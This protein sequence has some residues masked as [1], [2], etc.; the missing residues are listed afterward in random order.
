MIL[1]NLF[2]FL[3]LTLAISFTTTQI[4]HK[5]NK[6]PKVLAKLIGTENCHIHFIIDNEDYHYIS[7]IKEKLNIQVTISFINDSFKDAFITLLQ[8]DLVRNKLNN[9]FLSC[10]LVFILVKE[11][12]YYFIKD[13]LEDSEN[14][15]I[16]QDSS[17]KIRFDNRLA[18]FCLVKG[19]PKL[20]DKQE[21]NGLKEYLF[22]Y[23]N[24]YNFFLITQKSTK[25]YFLCAHCN[26]GKIIITQM[27]PLPFYHLKKEIVKKI[28]ERNLCFD[29][30]SSEKILFIAKHLFVFNFNVSLTDCKNM[31]I[32]RYVRY[33][34][35]ETITPDHL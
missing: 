11:Q 12:Y 17:K 31:V 24:L 33:V 7:D 21:I 30:N 13:Q 27:P 15:L 34:D 2:C 8:I 14:H 19:I 18:I 28:P 3:I 23:Q 4:H 6:I 22:R 32:A 10:F 35:I 29:E 1:N 16:Y 26:Y 5:E 20:G 25:V 9:N